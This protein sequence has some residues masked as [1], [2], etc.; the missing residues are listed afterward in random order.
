VP[1]HVVFVGDAVAAVEVARHAGDVERLA[2]VA[3]L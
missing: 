1:D 2:G 3:A